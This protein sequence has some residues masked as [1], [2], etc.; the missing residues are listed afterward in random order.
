M[1]YFGFNDP[2][3]PFRAQLPDG[4]GIEDSAIAE[5]VGLGA[6]QELALDAFAQ[7]RAALVSV[8]LL[9]QAGLCLAALIPAI[10]FGGRLKRWLVG[11]VDKRTDLALLRRLGGAAATLAAPLAVYLGLNLARLGLRTAERPTALIDAVISL[12]TA[13]IVIRLVTLLIRSSFWSRVAFF[14]A[15]PIAALDAFGVLGQVIDQMQALAIPLGER[16]DGGPLSISLFDVVR[17]ALYF[18]VLAWAASTAGRLLQDRIATIEELNPSARTLIVKVMNI[19]LPVIALMIAL[20]IVGFN[21]STLAVFSGAVGLGVGLGL[22]R[23][24]SNFTAGFTLVADRSI[25]PGDVITI[26]DTFGWVTSMHARYV[27]V[28]TRDGLEHL[29]P[30][31]QFMANG[32]INWSH[33]DKQVRLHAPFGVSYAT[34]DLRAV[35]SMAIEA[36]LATPRVLRIPRPVCNVTGFGDSSVDFDLRFWI[37]DPENGRGNVTSSV[38]LEIWDRLRAAGVEIPFPQRDVHVRSWSDPPSAA[39]LDGARDP[40]EATSSS[41]APSSAA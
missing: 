2:R 17:T 40:D 28:R 27:S 19:A 11:L 24:I 15:W 9:L 5:V 30:N 23:V 10:L 37:R 6:W 20:Q 16:E 34:E 38:Y 39:S 21:L 18:G 32:V 12:M 29:I 36:A 22:Q 7:I 3:A 35:Q 4:G 41:H 26:E 31:E 25:K 33:T 14:I 13:W 8:D 1:A